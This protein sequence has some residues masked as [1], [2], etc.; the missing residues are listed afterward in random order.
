MSISE[1]SQSNQNSKETNGTWMLITSVVPST[2]SISWTLKKKKS[3]NKKN[4]KMRKMKSTTSEPQQDKTQGKKPSNS[5]LTTFSQTNNESL[6]NRDFV[7][8]ASR[9]DI[10][11]EIV[12]SGRHSL[13]PEEREAWARNNPDK[14]TTI[15]KTTTVITNPRSGPST[16]R[17]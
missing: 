2:K 17:K 7:S 16:R 5:S 6:L 9:R 1:P 14:E 11:I 10:S 12:R 15:T 3:S 8:S 4:Q 13:K